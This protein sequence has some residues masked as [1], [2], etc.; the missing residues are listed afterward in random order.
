M[1]TRSDE[2]FT[3]RAA[4]L[5]WLWPGLGHLSLGQRRRGALIMSGVLFLFASGVL[6]GGV[7]CVDRRE[8]RLWFWAQ[9]LCGPI[10]F[11]V[12]LANQTLT[13]PLPADPDPANPQDLLRLRRKSL[14]RVNEMGT[15]YCALGGLMNLVVILDALYGPPRRS[16]EE[17]HHAE[18]SP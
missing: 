3:P 4:F 13:K 5:A 14:G 9:A 7:D 17:P 12:D 10:A 1:S 6:V 18:P 11:A 15:L 8:D 16:D 2:Q